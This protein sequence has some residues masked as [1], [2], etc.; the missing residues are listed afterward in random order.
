M[1]DKYFKSPILYDYTLALVICG[2]CYFLHY[3]GY[4]Q[5]PSFENTVAITSDLS[6]I[7]LTLAGFILTLLTVLITFKTGAKT[8]NG[9]NNEDVP[10]FDLFFS[11]KLYFQTVTLLKNCIKSLIFV[12]V[13]GFSL[14]IFL[15]EVLLKFLFFTNVLGL[16]IIVAT[17]WRSLLILTK[18]VALQKD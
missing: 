7:A 1:I 15:N 8:P 11:S 18:I 12:A 4:L 2:A 3:K 10:L 16:T 9:R 5:L 6:T 13:L 17:L 14:K